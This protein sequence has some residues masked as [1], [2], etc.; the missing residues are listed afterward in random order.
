MKK[1]NVLDALA[2]DAL[3]VYNQKKYNFNKCISDWDKYKEEC[4]EPFLDM[5]QDFFK[6]KFDL[7]SNDIRI[8]E[9]SI[10]FY[11]LI[12]SHFKDLV[13]CIPDLYLDFANGTDIEYACANFC[14]YILKGELSTIR[15][16][17]DNIISK[18]YEELH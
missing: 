9:W 4:I 2:D 5:N 1:I 12:C 15:K 16:T 14:I 10:I 8:K 18:E 6:Y 7:N 17:I 3:K 13:S 11:S